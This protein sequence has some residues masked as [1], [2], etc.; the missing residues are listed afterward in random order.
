MA[1]LCALQAE[2]KFCT[3]VTTAHCNDGR[4][5][6]LSIND[7][8]NASKLL[9][10]CTKARIFVPN[11]R[12]MMGCLDETRTLEY[13]QAVDVPSLHHMVDCMVFHQKGKSGSAAEKA[14]TI[15]C[16]IKKSGL[17]DL[18]TSKTP[19]ASI[20]VAL[21]RDTKLFEK[22]APSTYRVR[23]AYRKD[24]ADAESI[25]AEARKKIR[26]FENGILSGEDAN[27]VEREDEGE[28]DEEFEGECFC[29]EIGKE[30]V[31][32]DTN[33][34]NEIEGDVESCTIA[35][36]VDVSS[37]TATEFHKDAEDFCGGKDDQES[38]EIDESK[39]GELWV[40]GLT[41]G[42]YS[43]LSVEEHLNAL[44]ALIGIVNEGNSIRAVLEDRLEAATA[45]VDF[46]SLLGSKIEFQLPNSVLDGG[47]SS[48]LL[49][50]NKN[51]DVSAENQNSLHGPQGLQNDLSS[52]P[53]ERFSAVQDSCGGPGG[54]D[55]FSMQYGH[56]SKRSRTQLK[57]YIA[58][59]AEEIYVYRCLPLG[60]DCR[61]N[62]YWWF[63]ASTSKNWFR[64]DI[65]RAT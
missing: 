62:Q 23:S 45:K 4:C 28:R 16:K 43:H 42:E 27:E 26:I 33:L 11:G 31:S 51:N 49:A 24:P 15:M 39:S 25:L 6:T 8:S 19:E 44:V 9:D 14:L 36:S 32:D 57:S 54:P 20:S 3:R 2:A 55:N 5:G 40:H 12:S 56:A 47:H 10:L 37:K 38:V 53:T 59:R 7:A 29:P 58:H 22:I 13:G 63:V 30:N 48:W 18:T 41:E 65:C 60:Q 61:R 50:D 1:T 34:Q 35:G 46:L 21:T 52:V 64:Q 17:R